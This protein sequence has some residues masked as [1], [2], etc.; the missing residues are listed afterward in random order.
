VI[1]HVYEEYLKLGPEQ[2][3]TAVVKNEANRIL[4]AGRW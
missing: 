2:K 3:P 4:M 1:R